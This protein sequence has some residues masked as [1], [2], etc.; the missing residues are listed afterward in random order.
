MK[1]KRIWISVLSVVFICVILLA[2]VG[3]HLLNDKKLTVT[4]I[5]RNNSGE[6][7]NNRTLKV[8]GLNLSTDKN[9]QFI[10]HIKPNKKY[11]YKD[12]DL[13]FSIISKHKFSFDNKKKK[14]IIVLKGGVS[15][16]GEIVNKDKTI[17]M[18]I[19]TG[20]AYLDTQNKYN[21]DD[22][23]HQLNLNSNL[24]LMKNDKLIITP[25]ANSTG[26]A[27]Q[28]K[29]VI[30]NGNSTKYI[31]KDT[32]A[33]SVLDKL[34]IHKSVKDLESMDVES[35]N[36][37]NDVFQSMSLTLQE[38]D[39]Q[40]VSLTKEIKI[41]ASQ[42]N[43]VSGKITPGLTG[44]LE[45]DVLFN[46]INFNKS[47]IKIKGS[48]NFEPSS[49][50]K[51]N[52]IKDKNEGDYRIF[53]LPIGTAVTSLLGKIEY[54]AT[55][56]GNYK[57]NYKYR[58]NFDFYWS[59]KDGVSKSK[60]KK[61]ISE[62]SESL[63]AGVS[64]EVSIKMGPAI[65]FADKDLF[66]LYVG[67]KMEGNLSGKL[68]NSSKTNVVTKKA[69]GEMK[70]SMI[71][72][73][74]IPIARKFGI[75]AEYNLMDKELFDWKS[76]TDAPNDMSGSTNSSS[77]NDSSNHYPNMDNDLEKAEGFSD[78]Q[79]KSI[80]DELAQWFA[81]SKYG[82]NKA[83]AKEGLSWYHGAGSPSIISIDTQD[84]K[85]L[86][87]VWWAGTKMS[88]ITEEIASKSSPPKTRQELLDLISKND[89][90]LLGISKNKNDNNGSIY[91][92]N[93]FSIYGLNS[94]ETGIIKNEQDFIW[95]HIPPEVQNEANATAYFYENNISQSVIPIEVY[96]AT[97]GR[98]YF[99]E[100][101]KY[102]QNSPSVAKR[103][104]QDVQDEYQKLIKKY[105]NKETT[106]E[107]PTM[108]IEQ[109]S[110]GDYSSISGQWETKDGEL[111]IIN[112]NGITVENQEQHFFKE[113]QANYFGAPTLIVNRNGTRD[114]DANGA[115]NLYNLFPIGKNIPKT[116]NVQVVLG[117]TESDTTRERIVAHLDIIPSGNYYDT[118]KIFYRK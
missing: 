77:P 51:F 13:K 102:S 5:L 115:S 101:M 12:K 94:G 27:F 73:G 117:T 70:T 110:K 82:E 35:T 24:E 79:A 16:I 93:G 114:S 8:N 63:D 118:G 67:G 17:A 90:S 64:G 108:S 23:T 32:S 111:M 56:G 54:N 37:N 21:Y 87:G 60:V 6:I 86:Q 59:P 96:P 18:G 28:I 107:S 61:D 95:E 43:D 44:S 71:V 68:E 31:V 91:T 1:F 46:F 88:D 9:G 57:L 30:S 10:I 49:E 106:T 25:T 40:T 3:Y 45:E 98:V 104:P 15:E 14:D 103:A 75:K 92:T 41:D 34:E 26:H 83:I 2:I 105:K 72:G 89:F 99:I 19:K 100:R 33:E 62:W 55:L 69:I 97:N 53:C 116:E 36:N 74:G 66:Q 109:I 80:N 84:G 50:I 39:K 76:E 48:I 78:D 47:Y 22:R 4:G 29:K 42:S 113:F 38:K 52:A 58:P 81:E 11:D 85:M 7:I 20:V 65:T 112:G